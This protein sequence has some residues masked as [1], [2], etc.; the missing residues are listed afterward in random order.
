MYTV[1]IYLSTCSCHSQVIAVWGVWE[2]RSK[3]C[4][5]AGVRGRQPHKVTAVLHTWDRV[6]T[7]ATYPSPAAGLH[8]QHEREEQGMAAA[9]PCAPSTGES[10]GGVQLNTEGVKTSQRNPEDWQAG[11]LYFFQAAC[12]GIFPFQVNPNYYVTLQERKVLNIFREILNSYSR[13][14]RETVKFLS[15]P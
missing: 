5:Q 11:K 2:I 13:V 14:F 15:C 9:D 3:L 12:P 7:A 6:K 1:C 8:S 4:S 10:G